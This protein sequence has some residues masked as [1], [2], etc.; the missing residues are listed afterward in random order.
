MSFIWA[1]IS[2]EGLIL[3]NLKVS[4]TSLVFVIIITIP[5]EV[6]RMNARSSS[7]FNKIV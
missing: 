4:E 3:R 5:I 6:S 1:N 2:T 7:E